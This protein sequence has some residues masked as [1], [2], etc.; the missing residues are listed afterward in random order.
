M[1]KGIYAK[2]IHE[3]SKRVSQTFLQINCAAIPSDLLESEFDHFRRRF[4]AL[5]E[6]LEDISG[7]SLVKGSRI[8]FLDGAA[9]GAPVIIPKRRLELIWRDVTLKL[10][11]YLDVY[12]APVT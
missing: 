3:Q 2:F 5:T 4:E 7:G 10:R 9:G 8:S 11:G 6:S 1:G 12:F